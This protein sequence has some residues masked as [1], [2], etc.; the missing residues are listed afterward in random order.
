LLVGVGF[1]PVLIMVY[2]FATEGSDFQPYKGWLDWLGQAVQRLVSHWDEFGE[3]MNVWLRIM[4][5]IISSLMLLGVAVRAA[6]SVG[7]ERDRDTLSSL[8]TTPLSTREIMTAKWLGALWSVRGFI[9]WLAAVWL[10]AAIVGG[11]NPMAVLFHACAWIAPAMCFA[12]IGLW[13]SATASTTLRA[14]AWTIVAVI[15]AGGGH[16]LCTGMCCYAPMSIMFPRADDIEWLLEAQ[17][18]VTPPFIF[19]WDPFRKFS[20]LE[21]GRHSVMPGMAIAG[22]IVWCLAA[23]LIWSF[24]HERFE[25]LTHRGIRVPRGEPPIPTVVRAPAQN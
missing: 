3:G 8:M 21:L 23:K 15:F 17:L 14:T 18:G 6:G 4:N 11:V 13:F 24:A 7:G 10:L 20:E 25:R 22:L 12:S 5:V 2:V 9:W 16:W 19:G 1:V